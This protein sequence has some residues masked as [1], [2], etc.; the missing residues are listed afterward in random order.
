[1]FY[2][3]GPKKR[4]NKRVIDND[5]ELYW[6]RDDTNPNQIIYDLENNKIIIPNSEDDLNNKSEQI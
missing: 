2:E 6:E 1:L 4:K 3:F 5:D